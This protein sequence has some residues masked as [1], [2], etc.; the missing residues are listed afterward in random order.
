[1]PRLR[2]D[3][4][5]KMLVGGKFVR[6]ESGRTMPVDSTSPH[7]GKRTVNA[8]LASRKDVRDAVKAA[9]SAQSGWAAATAYNRGQILYRLAEMLDDRLDQL[10]VKADD[11]AAAVDRVIHHAGWTDKISAL[12]ST[13]NPVAATYVNYSKIRP[14]GVVA[15]A[16]DAADGLLGMV[17]ALCAS[18]V[19]GNATILFVPGRLAETAIALSEALA[20]CDLPAGVVNVLTG[21]QDELLGHAAAHDDVDGLYLAGAAGQKVKAKLDVEGARVMRRLLQVGGAASPATPFELGKLAEVQTVWMS[22]YEPRG[23]AA[24]Y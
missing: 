5:L 3:K 24:A 8:P 11:A 20:T 21:D 7:G 12:L 16:P 6:S 13:I 18:A 1:M 19:M 22:A 17:E 23:G 10:P 4:T 15:A 14:L 2:V 9:R